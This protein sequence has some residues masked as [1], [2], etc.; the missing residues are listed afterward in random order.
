[1]VSTPTRRDQ[2]WCGSIIVWYRGEPTRRVLVAEAVGG[3]ELLDSLCE[4]EWQAVLVGVALVV[5]QHVRVRRLVERAEG[6]V[7]HGRE[8]HL[9]RSIHTYSAAPSVRRAP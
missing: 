6:V 3:H 4:A 7:A 2:R 8:Q 1:M 9:Q 5:A